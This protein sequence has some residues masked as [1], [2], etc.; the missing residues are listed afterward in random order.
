MISTSPFLS[1]SVFS[2]QLGWSYR[3]VVMVNPFQETNQ[4]AALINFVGNSIRVGRS[5]SLRA[6]W[7]G[8]RV[9]VG[10]NLFLV[11]QTGPGTHQHPV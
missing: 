7:S 6:G 4:P 8:N 3:T 11:D 9:S 10:K 2:V 1:R 5:E